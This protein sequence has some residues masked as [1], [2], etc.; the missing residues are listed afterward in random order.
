MRSPSGR[1]LHA[2]P[3]A[4]AAT[5]A[6]LLTACAGGSQPATLE[7]VS[8]TL[9]PFVYIE[10][11]SEVVIT[12]GTLATRARAESNFFPLEIGMA[13]KNQL[14][15]LIL[16]RESF[17]VEVG[18]GEEIPAASAADVIEHYRA[19]EADRG[20]F[21]SREFT[22]LKFDRYRRVETRL[23]PNSQRRGGVVREQIELPSGTYFQD[24]LYFPNPGFSL[25]GQTARLMVRLRAGEDPLVVAFKIE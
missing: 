9:G 24:V 7:P 21:R 1:H 19:M 2:R 11:G 14:Q 25:R 10:E 8:R 17:T 18:D 23:Y 12:V 22:A 5:A 3:T 15:T 13:N 20:L 16:S 4:I 6:L